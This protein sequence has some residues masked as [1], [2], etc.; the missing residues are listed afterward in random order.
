MNRIAEKED[1]L[2]EAWPS[3]QESFVR[4]GIVDADE[5]ARSRVKLLFVPQ[6]G[7]RLKWWRLGP[8][9]VSSGRRPRTD[10]EH[11]DEMGR[12]H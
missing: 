6:G 8:T 11:G 9:R 5:Y 3:R 10:M 7:E 2:F 1:R 12:G 4:D